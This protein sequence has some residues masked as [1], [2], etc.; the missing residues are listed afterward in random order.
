MDHVWGAREDARTVLKKKPRRSLAKLNFDTIVFDP[1]Q[2]RHLVSLWGVDHIVVGTDYPYDMGWYDPRG[3]LDGCT[4]LKD[5]DKAKIL[6][7]NAA[8][9]LKLRAPARR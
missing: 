5:A 2:L 1:E 4:F 6:G 3:F 9:L 7:L 8:K